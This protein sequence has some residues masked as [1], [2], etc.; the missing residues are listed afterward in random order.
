MDEKQISILVAN[1]IKEALSAQ[2]A[3]DELKQ[4]RQE[5]ATLKNAVKALNEAYEGKETKEEEAQA[6]NEE[7]EESEEEATLENAK[8]SQ[9]LVAT[10]GN[11]LNIDFGSKTPSFVSL[12]NLL[13]IKEEDAAKRIAAVNAKCV[14]LEAGKKSTESAST[15]GIF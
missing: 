1:A 13:G 10:V 7:G 4:L 14:E 15:G 5:V 9:T 11:A 2:N 3:D 12:A 6:E 8:P